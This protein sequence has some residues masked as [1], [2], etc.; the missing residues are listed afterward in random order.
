MEKFKHSCPACGQRIEYTVDY[1]GKQVAC[2]TCQ[3]P[4]LFPAIPPTT[5]TQKLRLQRDAGPRKKRGLF[6]LPFFKGLLNFPHWK[7]VGACLIPFLLVGGLVWGANFLK[8]Q[9][10]DQTPAQTPR[11]VAQPVSQDAWNKMTQLGAVEQQVKNCL[12]AATVAKAAVVQAMAARDQLYG[13][14][15]GSSLPASIS[16]NVME[17]ERAADNKVNMAQQQFAAAC[18][19]FNTAFI[20]YQ[21]AG[22]QV[23]YRSQLPSY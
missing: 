10:A 12:R 8:S 11:A 20:N 7:V 18:Q 19:A 9:N 14:Y 16:Q 1:C 15:K 22:G 23:D 17:Q 2:P 21:N 3:A 4:V 6:D 5:A 13:M